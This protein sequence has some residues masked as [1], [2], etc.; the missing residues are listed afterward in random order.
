[1][2]YDA[3][4]SRARPACF[5]FLIDQSGS[6]GGKT[7]EGQVKAEVLADAI[8]EVLHSLILRCTSDEGIRDYFKIAIIGYG[9]ENEPDSVLSGRL[10]GQIF[11]TTSELS[12]GTMA[13]ETRV[14]RWPD[15]NGGFVDRV[16]KVPIWVRPVSQ[17]GTPMCA[18]LTRVHALLDTWVSEN[19]DHF[20]PIVLNITDAWAT[21]GDPTEIGKKILSL[22]TEDG[23]ALLFNLH[24]ASAPEQGDA[25]PEK[26]R[27]IAF[28]ATAD[29]LDPRAAALFA[30]SSPL[31]DRML[32]YA[33]E[34][35]VPLVS[36]S[37]GF[38]QNANIDFIVKFLQIGTRNVPGGNLL[39]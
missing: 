27:R 18:A 33:D 28:P 5:I 26:N 24:I 39:R 36:G 25:D 23:Y 13:V 14:E 7:S 4:I 3:E 32:R 6:M 29:G 19:Y 34:Y 10:S 30:I 31:P 9:A 15:G 37:R 8:N 2:P 38:V 11:A 1:M 21:D 17:Q 22:R 12:E 20:P 16:R 35:N